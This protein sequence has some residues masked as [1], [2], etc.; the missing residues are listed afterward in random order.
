MHRC[1]GMDSVPSD[2]GC[3]VLA[4]HMKKKH[5][6]QLDHVNSYVITMR[7]GVSGG[8]IASMM[9]I[10]EQPNFAALTKF[11]NFLLYFFL[12]YF[13]HAWFSLSVIFCDPI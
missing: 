3:Y 12:F 1:S 13:L 11:V 5:N 8:T 4:N 2:V 6:C 9:N 7:G 10:F